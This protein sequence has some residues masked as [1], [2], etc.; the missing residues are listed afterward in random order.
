MKNTLILAS[1]LCFV[2]VAISCKSR[3]TLNTSETSNGSNSKATIY[4]LIVSFISRGSG[5]NSEKRAAFLAYVE[6]HA[7]KPASERVSWGREGEVDYCF[8]LAGLSK[9]EQVEF[10][11]EIKNIVAGSDQVIVSENSECIHKRK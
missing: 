2:L 1:L 10:V 6:A 9:K 11:K 8:T 7:K 5:I 3:Q 4:R